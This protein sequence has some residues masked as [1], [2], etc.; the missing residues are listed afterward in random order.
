MKNKTQI[1]IIAFAV[2]IASI[3]LASASSQWIC[4]SKGEKMLFSE[5]NPI[6]DDYTCSST[7]CP[8]CANKISDDLY[9]PGSLPACNSAGACTPFGGGPIDTEPPVLTV[10][11]PL[12]NSVLKSR[13]VL[14][15]L[16]ADEISSFSFVENSTGKGRWTSLCSACSSYSRTRTFKEGIN[17]VTFR[18]IDMSGNPRVIKRNFIIDTKKPA[19]KGVSPKS[20]FA[21]GKFEVQFSESNPSSLII[22]YGYDS[23]MKS[24]A[25]SIQ[26][27]CILVKGIYSCSKTL[28]IAEFNDKIISYSFDLTDLAG[29]TASSKPVV[30]TADTEFPDML[31]IVYSLSGRNAKITIDIV[32]SNLYK[33]MYRDNSAVNKNWKT[34]CSSI[35]KGQCI[36][37][38]YFSYGEHL[39]DFQAIDKAG[40]SVS[41]SKSI[42]V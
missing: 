28:D 23:N 36:K 5:C 25:L 12:E 21:S 34:F 19:F 35:D 32:E 27:D 15:D 30:L 7:T 33:I 17:N 31:S 20:G 39:I 29:N 4:L 14:V 13:N 38:I 18:A 3:A 6:Y 37:S 10:I 2:L 16:T 26:N 9:C 1:A 22:H 24:S 42:N 8:V 11:K 40:N 41:M